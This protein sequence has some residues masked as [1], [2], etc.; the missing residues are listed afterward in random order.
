M[1]KYIQLSRLNFIS[2]KTIEERDL[3]HVSNPIDKVTCNVCKHVQTRN[4]SVYRVTHGE[5]G[6]D[7]QIVVVRIY[8]V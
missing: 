5:T 7:L 6:V 8:S 3:R 2:P 4:G 1:T